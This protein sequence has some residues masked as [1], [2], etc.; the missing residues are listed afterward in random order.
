MIMARE[1]DDEDDDD[2]DDDDD[3]DDDTTT[4]KLT[5]K[6]T[7]NTARTSIAMTPKTKKNSNGLDGR[8]RKAEAAA[9]DSDEDDGESSNEDIEDDTGCGT[10]DDETDDGEKDDKQ[11]KDGSNRSDR[12]AKKSGGNNDSG[13][14]DLLF[15]I[16][17][18]D[19]T[20][21]PLSSSEDTRNWT[22]PRELYRARLWKKERKRRRWES[23]YGFSYF[24]NEGPDRANFQ[25]TYGYME[26]PSIVY[27]NVGWNEDYHAELH[28]RVLRLPALTVFAAIGLVTGMGLA[29]V[30]LRCSHQIRGST[31]SEELP[32]EVFARSS[33]CE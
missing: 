4:T 15:N 11:D 25:D 20:R 6:I 18:P 23:M 29:A 5:T 19:D 13:G 27:D 2:D 1:R 17:Y 26:D 32:L 22:T 33:V 14:Q 30:V 28:P 10:G 31:E 7:R 9:A 16:T 3:E 24:E 21:D 8:K 12:A